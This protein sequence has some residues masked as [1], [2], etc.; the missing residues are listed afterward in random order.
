MP[1]TGLEVFDIR[2]GKEVIESMHER[3]IGRY[4]CEDFV[5]AETGRGAGVQG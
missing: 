3:L 1:P 5:D 4:L 2:D